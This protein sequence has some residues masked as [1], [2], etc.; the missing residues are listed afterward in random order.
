MYKHRDELEILNKLEKYGTVKVFKKGDYLFNEGDIVEKLYIVKKGK[1]K[2][3]KLT[4]S[5]DERILFIFSE[6]SVLNEEILFSNNST[7][8]TCCSTLEICEIVII[9][10]DII[11]NKM[12]SDFELVK[13]IMGCTTLKLKR[14]YRQLKNSGTSVTIEK[15]VASKLWKLALDYGI[16]KKSGIFID[17]ELSSSILSKMVGAKRETISRTLQML[18]K[19]NIIKIEGNKI[20]ILN[21]NKLKTIY[22]VE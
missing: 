9:H 3:Y 11:I 18:K 6:G 1:I 12:K 15:K 21:I 7:C 14:S 2:S 8:S 13:Y 10:K 16:E 19:N 20:T 17:V 5:W 4:K 22:D